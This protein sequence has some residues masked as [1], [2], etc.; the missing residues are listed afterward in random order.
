MMR[1]ALFYEKSVDKTVY[2]HLC[3]HECIIKNNKFGICGVRVNSKG[4][5][6]TY[7]YGNAIAVNVDPIEKKP[8]YHFLSGSESLSMA[9]AGCNFRCS[10]CQNWEI[11]QSQSQ[12]S[13]SLVEDEFS[14]EDIVEEAL[15]NNCR[16]ISYTYT[17]P[18]IFFEYAYDTSRLAKSRSL[19][20]VFIT[21]GYM[22]GDCLKEISSYLDAANVDLKFFREDS[23]RKYCAAS[24]S[25]VLETIRLMKELGIWVEITTLV[26]P[27]INDS[28]GELREL[29][30]FISGLDKNI[31]W[32]LSRFHP[33]YKLKNYPLTPEATL[34]EALRIGRESGLKF[35]YAGNV[36]GWGS[37][38]ICP[39]CEK[40]L[41]KRDGFK[42]K[43][44]NIN[45]GKCSY[46]QSTI[47]GV[48]VS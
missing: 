11:S 19:R 20:N 15:R 5:L 26:I 44:Y 43:E 45:M 46:C 32:H 14:P 29:A 30:G 22:S 1:E 23:Y 34:K 47:P 28:E 37:D 38:T 40:P 35:V 39:S 17:E 42:V 3:A 6:F 24:L 36:Y 41:I 12:G 27:G 7:S 31:P 48:F 2:C 16:S 10:F 9:S 8:L 18:T 21:N 25:P 4:T 13:I 33:D